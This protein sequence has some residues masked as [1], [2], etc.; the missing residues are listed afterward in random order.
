MLD[1]LGGSEQ[2][3]LHALLQGVRVG[4]VGKSQISLGHS[5]FVSAFTL[6]DGGSL[7]LEL[8]APVEIEAA[9]SEAGDLAGRGSLTSAHLIVCFGLANWSGRLLVISKRAF[10]DFVTDEW[11]EIQLAASEMRVL[12]QLIV[13]QSPRGAAMSDGIG[14]ETKRGYIK[15]VCQKLNLAGQTELVSAVLGRLLIAI[16]SSIIASDPAP[17]ST[18][19]KIYQ[20][21]YL[22]EDSRVLQMLDEQGRTH[23]VLDIGALSARPVVV[24]VSSIPPYWGE[25]IVSAISK[26][27]LRLLIPLR[28]GVLDPHARTLTP[29][30][31]HEHAIAGLALTKAMLAGK[32]APVLG[33]SSGGNNAI[34]FANR[35]PDLVQKLI[36]ASMTF[37][38]PRNSTLL[39]RFLSSFSQ[40]VLKNPAV[41][42][43][44]VDQM[45]RLHQ[46]PIR[47][48]RMNDRIFPPDSADGRAM[49]VE[50]EQPRAL[51]A[52]MH[53][54]QN[55]PAFL[56]MDAHAGFYVTESE[57]LT[58]SC[59]VH[60]CHG[61]ANSWDE[62][63]SIRRLAKAM[64]NAEL[65]EIDHAGHILRA[66]NLEKVLDI[67]EENG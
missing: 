15:A 43:I 64:P 10:T 52:Y 28:H 19:L 22:P 35:H 45:L 7:L 29:D 16:N 32:D 8:P 53:Y 20:G 6:K 60:V 40:M 37:Q 30:A 54:Y 47:F 31:F 38:P 27:R 56:K 1:V 58:L 9:I 41:V 5:V 51:E 59:H 24:A 63:Q 33:L 36:L 48:R 50:F 3:S 17:S 44:Y 23:R 42:S 2:A 61:T 57:F 49:Q 14:Y 18:A 67:V 65:T 21:R 55:S 26:R 12:Q 66:N 62:I 46:D 34:R 11:P 39:A 25:H 4:K 13:G